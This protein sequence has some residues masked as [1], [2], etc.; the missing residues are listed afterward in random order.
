MLN[1]RMWVFWIFHK[2]HSCYLP[3]HQGR[4]GWLFSRMLVLLKRF[5]EVIVGQILDLIQHRMMM[6]ARPW[7]ASLM[8]GIL[9]LALLCE[10]YWEATVSEGVFRDNKWQAACF[11]LY[12][13]S[14]V[15]LCFTM[16]I[17]IS[18][19]SLWAGSFLDLLVNTDLDIAVCD[20]NCTFVQV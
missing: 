13:D 9:M 2:E 12:V 8:M 16:E 18:S 6:I 11:L 3:H 19:F 4:N 17:G 20:F 1:R 15:S 5:A 10:E 14:V 7:R